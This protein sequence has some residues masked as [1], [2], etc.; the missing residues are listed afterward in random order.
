MMLLRHCSQY[1]TKCGKPRTGKGQF[2][3]KFQRRAMTKSIQATRHCTCNKVI[4]K[5][6]KLAFSTLWTKNFQMYKRGSQE[7]EEPEARLPTFTGLW[8]KQG[9]SRKSATFASLSTL[10][11]LCGHNKLWE[12]L[13][14][15]GLLHNLTCLLRSLHVSQESTTDRFQIGKGV[16]QGCLSPSCLTN[17]HAEDIMWNAR[18]NESQAGTKVARRNISGLR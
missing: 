3:F 8:N 14:E 13:K 2:L 9:D 1:V 4:S 18:C 5:S 17:L 12:I 7:A 15:M 6:L 11:P 16:W 10:Q